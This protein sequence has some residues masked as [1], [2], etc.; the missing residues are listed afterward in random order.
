MALGADR[1]DIM[2]L[3][4]RQGRRLV[5]AGVVVGVV[6]ACA[7]THAIGKLLMGVSATDP[8]TYTF[9]VVLLSAV[10][11]LAGWITSAS[12]D[13]RRPHAGATNGIASGKEWK[14]VAKAASILNC[15]NRIIK[16]RPF[17]SR[18]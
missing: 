7:L 14:V 6:V 1:Y 12:S 9:V 10:T 11:L 5:I 4:S 3:V 17:W 8:A 2:K 15:R 16:G 13:A 18:L